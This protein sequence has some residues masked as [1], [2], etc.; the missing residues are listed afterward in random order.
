MALPAVA[1]H[2]DL[3][4]H[5]RRSSDPLPPLDDADFA[6][7][8]DRFGDARVVLLGEGTHGTSEFYRARS[9]ITRRL[10]DRHGFRVV[11]IEGD[12]PDAADLDRFA[13]NRGVWGQRSTFV[14]FP[15]WMWRNTEFRSFLHAL[16]AWNLER[17]A[18]DRAGQQ[19]E[20]QAAVP[21]PRGTR[22]CGCGRRLPEVSGGRRTGHG[23]GRQ[24]CD[25]LA[26]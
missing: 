1:R 16:R 13:R 15:R 23:C 26:A 22:A 21:A 10:I 12:W 14:N 6:A 24:A 20:E 19:P 2:D 9:A 3:I 7:A 5:L 11:A 4:D 17:P 18:D 8:F 25:R